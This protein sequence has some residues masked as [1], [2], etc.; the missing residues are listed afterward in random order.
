[1]DLKY[2]RISKGEMKM[3]QYEVTLRNGKKVS[4]FAENGFEV[5]MKCPN[6]DSFKFVKVLK[7]A[8]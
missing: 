1:M 4:C 7:E 6:A 5:C 8:K 3:N 2:K